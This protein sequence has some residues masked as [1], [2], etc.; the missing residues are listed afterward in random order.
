MIHFPKQ[1]FTHEEQLVFNEIG[2]HQGRDFAI[3]VPVLTERVNIRL[4]S[5]SLSEI[6]IRKI[7]RALIVQ[8][9]IPIGSATHPPAGYYIITDSEEI[10]DV[11]KSLR[12]RGLKILKR[13]SKLES[14]GIRNFTGQME[15]EL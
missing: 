15:L 8:H 14:C 12:Q 13:A 3:S 4:S 6:Q 1:N 9:G 7:V 10:R 2:N 5:Y 11:V